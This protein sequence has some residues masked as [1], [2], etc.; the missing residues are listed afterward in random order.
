MVKQPASSHGVPDCRP[1]SRA[2]GVCPTVVARSFAGKTR[3]V[4]VSSATAPI[5]PTHQPP[6][7]PSVPISCGASSSIV[8]MPSAM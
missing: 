3:S 2:P 7:Q 6:R 4:S 5:M 1:R 8:V